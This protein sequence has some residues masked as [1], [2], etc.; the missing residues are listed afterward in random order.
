MGTRGREDAAGSVASVEIHGYKIG[1]GVNLT[2]ADLANS[3]MEMNSK[4]WRLRKKYARIIAH[5]IASQK[6]TTE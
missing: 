5:K 4:L 6:S 2:N 1:L 3:L